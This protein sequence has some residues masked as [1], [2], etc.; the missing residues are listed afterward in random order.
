MIRDVKFIMKP[1]ILNKLSLEYLSVK[2]KIFLMPF[3][4][5]CAFLL[6]LFIAENFDVRNERLLYQI[7]NGY[8]PAANLGNELED[9]LANIQR[10][11]QFAVSSADEEVLI[12]VDSLKNSFLMYLYKGKS[13]PTLKVEQ[14]DFIENTFN[15]GSG[16]FL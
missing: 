13:N 15:N 5:A 11:M 16:F 14:L 12:E 8:I 3:L 6:I 4:A 10:N 9:I 1:N 2:H 7:E